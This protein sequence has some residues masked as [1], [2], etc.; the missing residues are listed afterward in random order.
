MIE[1]RFIVQV[2]TDSWVA[3]CD[4]V[5]LIMPD[6]RSLPIAFV[7]LHTAET[8]VSFMRRR[9]LESNQNLIEF[10]PQALFVV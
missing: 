10:S 8:N 3:I 1:I 5:A 4:N 2:R 9:Q 6:V 7:A